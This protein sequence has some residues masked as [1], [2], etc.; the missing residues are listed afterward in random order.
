M[1]GWISRRSYDYNPRNYDLRWEDA[2]LRVEGGAPYMYEPEH[3]LPQYEAKYDSPFTFPM[4]IAAA[5]ALRGSPPGGGIVT[6]AATEAEIRSWGR[7]AIPDA[8]N[9]VEKQLALLRAA[10]AKVQ[11]R[12]G[13]RMH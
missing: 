8:G 12:P 3:G 6:P 1:R 4:K 5:C 7:V 13:G 11:P 9:S 2:R 10:P